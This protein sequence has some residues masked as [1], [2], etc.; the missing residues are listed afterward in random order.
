ML[1]LLPPPPPL[2]LVQIPH[3]NGFA[4]RWGWEGVYA[5]ADTRVPRDV[6]GQVSCRARR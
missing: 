6:R 2:V 3:G 4:A 1:R 5:I